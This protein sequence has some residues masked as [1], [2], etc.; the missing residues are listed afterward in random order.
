[1]LLF[2][3]FL[4]ER[5]L[6]LFTDDRAIREKYAEEVFEKL[7]KAYAKIGGIHGSG[8]RSPDDMVRNLPMWKL[9]R[10]GESIVSGAFYKD[11]G[12]RKRVAVFTDGTAEGKAALA[13]QIRED[14]GRAFNE[15]SGPMLRFMIKEVGLDFMKKY[16]IPRD[17]AAALLAPDTLHDVEPDDPELVQHPYF[18][19]YFYRRDIGGEL[20]TKAMF[21]TP[22]KKIVVAI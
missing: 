10:R 12:G 19:E 16:A 15:T 17:Q 4:A 2:E 8:F 3:Q 18:S 13:M 1:M 9:I 11:K 20:H 7:K 22:G 5:V 14:F 6:N 21:G